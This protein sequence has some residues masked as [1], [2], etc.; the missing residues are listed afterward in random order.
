[1]LALVQHGYP[2]AGG[3][4]GQ[5]STVPTRKSIFSY[6]QLVCDRGEA[7]TQQ[8]VGQQFWLL[9]RLALSIAHQPSVGRILSRSMH[10]KN[11]LSKSNSPSKICAGIDFSGNHHMWSAG[12]GNS[13]VWIAEVECSSPRPIL[14][15]L[16]RVQQLSGDGHPFDRLIQYLRDTDFDAA[17]IDAPFSVP[18]EYLQ[19]RTHSELLEL[20]GR[21]KLI[22]GRPFPCA[23]DFVDLVLDGRTT[24]NKKPLR[25]TEEYWRNRKVNVRCTLWAGSRGGAAM[26]AACLKLLYEAGRPVWPWKRSVRGLLPEALERPTRTMYCG[27]K[28]LACKAREMTFWFCKC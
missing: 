1:M 12:C 18:A 22:D 28:D 4:A 2:Y 19:P 7:L 3:S 6:I 8:G 11:L 13:N 16:K 5:L 23:R 21:V 10:G 9:L 25:R 14:V 17:A 26:T 20:I 15:S 24:A 27:D